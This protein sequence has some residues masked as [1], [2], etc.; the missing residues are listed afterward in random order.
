[1]RAYVYWAQTNRNITVDVGS[2]EQFTTINQALEYLSGFY[3]M[4]KKVEL[5]QL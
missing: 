1:M 5:Q 2:G 4:Y 3:P